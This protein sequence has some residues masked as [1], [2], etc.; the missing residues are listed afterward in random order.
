MKNL[1][2]T[3]A[4]MICGSMAFSAQEQGSS[5]KSKGLSRLQVIQ[6]VASSEALAIQAG[7]RPDVAAIEVFAISNDGHNSRVNV[8][9]A[10]SVGIGSTVTY[11]ASLNCEAGGIIELE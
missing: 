10:G 6:L 5:C 2:L 7:S 9:F 8:T 11:K 4:V 1:V 3:L